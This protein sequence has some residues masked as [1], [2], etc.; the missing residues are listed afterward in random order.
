[1]LQRNIHHVAN[2]VSCLPKILLVSLNLDEDFVNEKSIA[3][4]PVPAKK[5]LRIFRAECNTSQSNRLIADS[6]TSLCHKILYGAAA[7]VEA[8]IKPDNRLNEFV[9][10]SVVLVQ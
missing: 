4:A 7:Q 2:P 8:M 9:R 10:E 5:S 1:M 6:N 3:V